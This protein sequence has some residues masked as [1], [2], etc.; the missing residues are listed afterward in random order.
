MSVAG[1][2]SEQ[3]VGGKL[4]MVSGFSSS[5][6][7]GDVTI[8]TADGSIDGKTASGSLHISTGDSYGES[9]AAGSVYIES[10]TSVSGVGG[11]VIIRA[12]EGATSDGGDVQMAA[13]GTN[14]YASRGAKAPMTVREMV[15]TAGPSH[16]VEV[17]PTAVPRL[18]PVETPSSEE[19][20][21]SVINNVLPCQFILS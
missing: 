5:Q 13:G 18:M 14:G 10:G 6:A 16:F 11:Q 19:E 2:F 9:S 15:E 21:V 12:N 17:L 3:G 4:L 1:G 8:A 7:S 20:I